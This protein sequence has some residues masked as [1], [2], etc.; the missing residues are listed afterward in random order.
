M[1]YCNDTCSNDVHQIY[2]NTAANAAP[3]G[4]DTQIK[5]ASNGHVFV[6]MSSFGT[7][8]H[9]FRNGS[10]AINSTVVYKIVNLMV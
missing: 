5:F 1:H 2:A 3:T 9:A 4:T 6:V 10:R 8:R 7:L